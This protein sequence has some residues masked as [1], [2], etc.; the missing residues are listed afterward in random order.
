M[1]AI[2]RSTELADAALAD[3][4]ARDS[5]MDRP[6][7][8]GIG[9]AFLDALNPELAGRLSMGARRFSVGAGEAIF[10][11]YDDSSGIV[12]SGITRTFMR[13]PDGRQLSVRY[14]RQGSV[15]GTVTGLRRNI[16]RL[17][18]RAV[19]AC[20]IVELDRS[21]FLDLVA[22]N[23]TLAMA[24]IEEVG[25]RLHDVYGTLSINAFG[26]IRERIVDT[27]MELAQRDGAS[28]RLIA[29]V[30]QQALADGI[31]SVREV[32]AR[33]LALLR[34]EGLIET[35]KGEIVLLDPERLAVSVAG[36]SDR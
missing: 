11:N 7:L 28:G 1:T 19:T 33:T 29:P 17:T 20:E 32:V 16:A 3:L 24:V 8:D 31:G 13:S 9:G 6:I 18:V 35:R 36:W 10:P 15:I 34:E 27:L 26:S 4:L 22:S 12:A 21:V 14:A 23:A 25:R 30:T 5:R 2:P